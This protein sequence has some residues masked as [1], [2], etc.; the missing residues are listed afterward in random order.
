MTGK[1]IKGFFLGLG[2][3]VLIIVTQPFHPPTGLIPELVGFLTTVPVW[4][5]VLIRPGL[6]P[7]GEGLAILVYLA[8]AGALLGAAFYRKKL[9]G[10]LF[11]IALIIH[12]Y[13]MDERVGRPLGEILQS[14]LNY[15][16]R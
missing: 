14:F 4:I 10:W 8:V 1:V 15:F 13:I 12:H 7:L 11:L 6:T 16:N 9:W 5:A 2:L 3:A